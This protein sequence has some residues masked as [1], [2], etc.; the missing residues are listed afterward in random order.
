MI[1]RQQVTGIS[2][3]RCVFPIPFV[4][5]CVY[6]FSL[7]PCPHV[8]VRF[9]KKLQDLFEMEPERIRAITGPVWL[10][11]TCSPAFCTHSLSCTSEVLCAVALCPSCHD[12]LED[13][14]A[15]P[16]AD[17]EVGAFMAGPVSVPVSP[18]QPRLT[19]SAL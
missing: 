1:G 19:H 14:D 12:A 10:R 11:G 18:K 9:Q 8:Q 7:S 16:P 15:E 5:H 2:A 13:P 3:A 17:L 6:E 4:C